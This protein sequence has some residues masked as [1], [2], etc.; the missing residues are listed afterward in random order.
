VDLA[1]ALADV[2]AESIPVNFLDPRP[3]TPLAHLEIL[4]PADALRCLAMFR[5]VNPS[6]EIRVAGGREVCLRHLQPLALYPANSLFSE[7]YLTT[8]GQGHSRDEAMIREAGFF[9]SE[10]EPA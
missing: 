10:L 4:S 3:G 7:G 2:Q 1:F 6:S 5:F 9:V 8:G